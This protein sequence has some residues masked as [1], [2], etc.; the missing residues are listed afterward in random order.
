MSLGHYV[1]TDRSPMGL[2]Q[3]NGPGEY[4]GPHTASSVFLY[5]FCMTIII[6]LVRISQC[7]KI[8]CTPERDISENKSLIV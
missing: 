5:S 2:G 1:Y 8:F 3:Y 4:S 7:Q 6:T